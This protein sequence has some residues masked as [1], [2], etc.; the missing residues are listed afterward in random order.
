MKAAEQAVREEMEAAAVCKETKKAL[1]QAMAQIQ[2]LGIS[3][4][5]VDEQ[6]GRERAKAQEQGKVG[7]CAR[8][9]RR[10]LRSCIDQLKDLMAVVL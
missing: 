5:E 8:M 9:F 3:F 1:E 10:L 2:D 4:A 6:A 7:S